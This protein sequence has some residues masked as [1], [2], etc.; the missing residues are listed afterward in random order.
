[1]SGAKAAEVRPKLQRAIRAAEKSLREAEQNAERL[2]LLL[3]IDFRDVE[4]EA[5]ALARAVD[6]NAV[7]DAARNFCGDDARFLD[8]RR[9]RI[10][11]LIAEGKRESQKAC[12]LRR[13]ADELRR[14]SLQT[15]R[16]VGEKMARIERTI[17]WR[18]DYLDRENAEAIHA[19]FDAEE[20]LRWEKEAADKL[21]RAADCARNAKNAFNSAL[22]VGEAFERDAEN[23][24]RVARER[25]TAARIAE[26]NRRD[27]TACGAEID[28]LTASLGSLN[29]AKFAPG[30]NAAFERF[31]DEIAAFRKTLQSNDFEDAARSGET[32]RTRLRA[33]FQETSARQTAFET[34]RA[35]AQNALDAARIETELFDREKLARWADD[36]AATD[37][38]Y[39]RLDEARR[40]FDAENFARTEELVAAA[41]AYLRENAKL[42]D[43]RKSASE[44]R[45]DLAEVVMNA[46]CERG[47]DAPTFYYSRQNAD[48]SDVEF[49]DLTIFAKAPGNKGDMRM[50]VDLDG[51]IKLEVEG[52]P[53]GEETVCR[54]A[55][56]D[57]QN[58][59]G[60]EI[61]F[62]MT[63]WGR[64]ALATDAQVVCQEQDKTQERMRK[65]Q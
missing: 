15:M 51:K 13:E 11:D 57:L 28:G 36:R 29:C 8:E 7:S 21:R 64:A 65:R 40:E 33:F 16:D 25:E 62:R 61:D 2:R 50:E 22:Y 37:D 44:R 18:N 42:A 26:K 4:T 17:A 14:R 54:Q 20:A 32:L 46:L 27:A 12:D 30:G 47:Y 38:A 3:A 41:L 60:E 59:V 39:W 48:G 31:S 53:E 6:E 49:S 52:I 9:G 24:E 1:M 56:E 58:C 23:L 63:D 34:A 19:R 45:F 10:A 5:D 55:L 35:A 43:E